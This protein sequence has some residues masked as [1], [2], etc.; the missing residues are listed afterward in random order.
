[1]KQALPYNWRRI[2]TRYLV[3]ILVSAA[4][5]AGLAGLSDPAAIV[6]TID[7]M[8]PTAFVLSALAVGASLL[9]TAVRWWFLMRAARF[10]NS[11]GGVVGARMVGHL[12]NTLLPSG[13]VGDVLQVFL[14]VRRPRV[15]LQ[16][17]LSTSLADRLIGLCGLLLLVLVTLPWVGISWP[18]VFWITTLALTAFAGGLLALSAVA[19][20]SVGHRAGLPWRAI[21]FATAVVRRASLRHKGFRLLALSVSLS[22]I[23]QLMFTV[24][25]WLLLNDVTSV[26][27][28]FSVPILALATLSAII[29]LTV[30]GLGVREWIIFGAMSPFGLTV[31]NAL[32]VSLAWFTVTLLVGLVMAATAAVLI[33]LSKSARFAYVSKKV[34]RKG[35]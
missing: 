14:V 6:A 12:I 15:S 20:V 17:A 9:V 8:R 29:P 24:A 35:S 7:R 13:M 18:Q 3:T 22:V 16:H 25:P 19:R 32:A 2:W 34:P 10:P 11:L 26:P 30:S 28:L 27:F 21:N 23:G 33:S 4:L 5:L 31:E 1:M